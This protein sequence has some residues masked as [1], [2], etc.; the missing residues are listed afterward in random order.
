[1]N[2]LQSAGFRCYLG[3]Q[4]G[5]VP[6]GAGSA[7]FLMKRLLVTG[8]QMAHTNTYAGI[9]DAAEVLDPIRGNVPR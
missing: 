9:F 1:M 8:S 2:V 6:A 3:F 7:H 5:T 4:S